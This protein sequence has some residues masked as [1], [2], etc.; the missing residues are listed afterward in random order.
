[1]LKSVLTVVTII[2][3]AAAVY[4]AT[5]G[6]NLKFT[7][8]KAAPVYFSHEY[9]VDVKGIKCMACHLHRFELVRGTYKMKKGKLNKRD[10]CEFCHNGL[11][12]FDAGSTKNCNRCHKR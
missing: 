5:G 11:K 1:M 9:H 4:S 10:F 7:P 3:L 8:E 6:G 12:G 2:F